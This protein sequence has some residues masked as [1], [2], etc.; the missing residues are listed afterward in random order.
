MQRAVFVGCAAAAAAWSVAG[1]ESPLAFEVTVLATA[2]LVLGVPHGA[3][4]VLHAKRAYRLDRPHRWGAFLVAYMAL[5]A[6]VVVGWITFPAVSLCVLLAISAFHFSGDLE[7]GSPVRLRVAHGLAPVCLPGLLHA[8][9]LRDLFAAL[10]PADFSTSLAAW[11]EI[12]ARPVMAAVVFSVATSATRWRHASLEVA[13]TALVCSLAP[14]LTGFG[15]YFCLLHSWRHVSRTARLYTPSRSEFAWGVL[16]PTVAT[17]VAGAFVLA[18]LEPDTWTRG[19][20]QVVF[21]GLAALTVPH[22]VLIE[23]IRLAGWPGLPGIG[24]GG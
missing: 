21:V 12:A 10:A 5:A 14:P 15:L 18:A 13:A 11:M 1:F 24:Q 7:A 17:G 3:L 16:A 23:R 8:D 20:L 2:V 6:A 4:D 9:A 22:M 19:L